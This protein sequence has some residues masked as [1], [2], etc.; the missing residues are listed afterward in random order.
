MAV[1][2]RRAAAG[3]AGVEVKIYDL[4]GE[5][6]EKYGENAALTAGWN[7]VLSWDG[8]NSAGKTVGMGVYFMEIKINNAAAMKR[9]I[10]IK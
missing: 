7:R 1:V 8:R 3:T 5:L 9:V 6:V 4:S 10:V 2:C